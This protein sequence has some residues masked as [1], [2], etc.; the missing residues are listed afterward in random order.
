MTRT[1]RISLPT[2]TYDIA[3]A[4]RALDEIGERLAYLFKS[5]RAFVV[6]DG[7]LP[8]A[9]VENVLTR[10]D[11]AGFDAATSAI[12]AVETRKTIEVVSRLLHE[13]ALAGLDRGDPIIALGGGLTGDVAGF[14]AATYKRGCPI[15]QCPTSLL[16]MVDASVGGK[17]GVNLALPD[18]LRKNLVGSFHQP[19]LVLADLDALASLPDR[20]FRS[21]LGECLKHA[22]ISDAVDRD[23]WDWTASHMEHLLGRDANLLP[24]LIE[25]GVNVKA[26]FVQS[27][28]REQD[29][30]SASSRMML[31]L[32]HTFAH[33]LEAIEGLTPADDL[34]LRE[35]AP[36]LLHG[37]AVAYG[38]LA[39]ARAAHAL[40]RLAESDAR[41]IEAG[42]TSLGLPAH[43]QG[44]LDPARALSLMKHDKK[45]QGSRLRLVLPVALGRC[46]IVEAPDAGIVRDT[47]ASIVSRD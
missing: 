22:L 9:L 32:G 15:V 14:V 41:A 6:V 7:N 43:V 33:A 39:A 44:P 10:L 23:L 3:I 27:D 25:R 11:E 26:H 17:T 42:V 37:E 31:N 4:P 18:G 13:C 1:A 34:A 16:A 21:G 8:D 24:Q 12:E 20:Q 46:E 19:S 28:E 45:A 36:R 47:I 40:G 38:L 5:R 30:N 35:P 29:T 2:A